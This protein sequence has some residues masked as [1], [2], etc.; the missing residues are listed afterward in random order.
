MKGSRIVLYDIRLL[1]F[2]I[3]FLILSVLFFCRYFMIS[4][5]KGSGVKDLV[6]YLMEQACLVL[7]NHIITLFTNAYGCQFVT[8]QF[9]QTMSCYYYN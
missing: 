1:L 2:K 7:I 8:S 4:G 5:L 3:S 6:Q 9:P